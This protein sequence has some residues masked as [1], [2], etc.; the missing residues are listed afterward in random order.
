MRVVVVGVGVLIV[1][2]VGVVV[3]GWSLT[4]ILFRELSN[5]GILDLVAGVCT[6]SSEEI[7]QDKP[8]LFSMK[9]MVELAV[10]NMRYRRR[11][12]WNRIWKMLANHF[13]F[14]GC[15]KVMMTIFSY[16]TELFQI[17]DFFT[18]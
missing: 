7:L 1:D 10:D 6:V 4:H 12:V 15:Q 16:T 13:T 9:K 11:I 3:G 5:T 18:I 17:C 8:S 14:A 2:I